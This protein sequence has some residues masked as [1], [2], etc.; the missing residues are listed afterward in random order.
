MAAN[1]IASSLAMARRKRSSAG[2]LPCCELSPPTDHAER[3]MR[4]RGTTPISPSPRASQL[5]ACAP[6]CLRRETPAFVGERAR[7]CVDQ[8]GSGAP[9]SATHPARDRCHVKIVPDLR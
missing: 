8:G 6:L 5:A 9:R 7:R 4:L 3:T 2:G 1:A